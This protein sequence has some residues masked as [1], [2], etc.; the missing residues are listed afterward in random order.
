MITPSNDERVVKS[1]YLVLGPQGL[2]GNPNRPLPAAKEEDYSSKSRRTGSDLSLN[3]TQY[4]FTDKELAGAVAEQSAKNHA[5]A[6][7]HVL[8]TSEVFFAEISPPKTIK[9]Q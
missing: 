6:P 2:V 9:F 3:L 1:L 8:S 5:N 4:L 7:Y